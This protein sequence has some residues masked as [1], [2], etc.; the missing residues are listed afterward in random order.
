MS[1]DYSLSLL[2]K[3][4]ILKK[5]DIFATCD[6]AVSD[7][8]K[9]QQPCNILQIDDILIKNGPVSLINI[10]VIKNSVKY[11]VPNT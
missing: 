7:P 6:S 3:I 2:C 11:L 4:K 5:L 8:L 10:K 9:I 1:M